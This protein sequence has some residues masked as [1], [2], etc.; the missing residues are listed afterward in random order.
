MS[1]VPH[2]LDEC[3]VP[4]I[5]EIRRTEVD[6]YDEGDEGFLGH[7][8]ERVSDTER[9]CCQLAERSACLDLCTCRR[10]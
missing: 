4:I 8:V 1:H 3:T 7:N 10:P 5:Q 9:A 6:F 2:L